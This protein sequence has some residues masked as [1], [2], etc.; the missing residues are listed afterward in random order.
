MPI[1]QQTGKGIPIYACISVSNSEDFEY[2]KINNRITAEDTG[3]V[4]AVGVVDKH[5]TP[6][7]PSVTY[8]LGYQQNAGL[9]QISGRLHFFNDTEEQSADTYISKNNSFGYSNWLKP[10]YITCT[11]AGSIVRE[12]ENNSSR[13]FHFHMTFNYQESQSLMRSTSTILQLTTNDGNIAAK[14]VN[15]SD[16]A[17][18]KIGYRTKGTNNTPDTSHAPTNIPYFGYVAPIQNS[19]MS[20]LTTGPINVPYWSSNNPGTAM[21]VV[22]Y[23]D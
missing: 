22:Y 3:Q 4:V 6:N 21:Y 12:E 10:N 18:I 15:P 5:P 16:H 11:Y 1:P 17:L 20:D 9:S 19:K 14:L 7:N 8:N 13:N 2:L 23:P